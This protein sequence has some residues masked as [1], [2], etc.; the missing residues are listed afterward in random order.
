MEK[1][2]G[3]WK[4]EFPL[5]RNGTPRDIYEF[6]QVPLY[7]RRPFLVHTVTLS[8]RETSPRVHPPGTTG[9]SIKTA[10]IPPERFESEFQSIRFDRI[11]ILS[12][13]KRETR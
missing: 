6:C 4:K 3:R 12:A 10:D 13:N 1:K 2:K 8:K 9:R 11:A 7:K 5:G